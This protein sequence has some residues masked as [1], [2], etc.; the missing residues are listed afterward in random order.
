M[1]QMP[2]LNLCHLRALLS[3]D[4]LGGKRLVDGAQEL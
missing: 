1:S 2:V 4:S 3:F